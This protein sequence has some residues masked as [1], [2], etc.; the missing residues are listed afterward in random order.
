[1][2]HYMKHVKVLEVKKA[3]VSHWNDIYRQ[4]CISSLMIVNPVF[5]RA[6]YYYDR[7]RKRAWYE[8]GN[9]NAY[10]SNTLHHNFCYKL[11]KYN[12]RVLSCREKD[13]ILVLMQAGICPDE[14]RQLYWSQS[15]LRDNKFRL[16]FLKKQ[17]KIPELLRSKREQSNFRF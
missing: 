6:G 5:N 3:I 17:D 8:D 16:R 4:E 14:L 11:K 1:M 15:S 10:T 2:K 7:K 12:L 9:G 13:A